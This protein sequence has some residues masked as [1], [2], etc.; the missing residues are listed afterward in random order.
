MILV[1]FSAIM[2]QMIFGSIS[3]SK[4]QKVDGVYKTSEFIN[5][6]K[7]FILGELFE[8]YRRFNRE[9]GE[10]VIALDTSA[11]WRRKIYS[12]YKSTRKE[13][14]D[15]SEI[16][17][18]EVFFDINELLDV[19]DKN[20]PFKVIEV[21][22]AEGDDV[23]LVLADYF[24][25]KNIPTLIISSDKD[26][27]QA[28]K[29]PSVKQYSHT[30]KQFVTPET[31]VKDAENPMDEW[32][33]E[34]VVLGDV[35]D[36]IPR[37]TDGTRFAPDF[38]KHLQ[39]I[40]LDDFSPLDFEED[41][42]KRNFALENYSVQMFNR[43][44]QPTGLKI[45]DNP[46]LGLQSVKKEIK[47]YGSLENWLDTSDILKKHFKRNSQLILQEYIPENIRENIMKK[48]SESSSEY[49]EKE[50][51]AYCRKNNLG[52]LLSDLPRSFKGELTV[53]SLL[54]GW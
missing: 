48:Y 28:Q 49:N 40:G 18:Q 29:H 30:T 3:A 19:L 27:I 24:G 47:K 54:E 25:S 2:H 53:S 7:N 22:E 37:I 10:M 43:K 15:K 17:Y 31:K 16:N 33:I 38:I 41:S 20:T 4:P 46:K 11:S 1:D 51:T 52:N 13:N 50:F 5:I 23:I 14:R 9:Y 45:F 21:P 34:H 12:P 35:A 8:F 26:M 36:E 39:E 32:L 6:T 44:G 42:Q